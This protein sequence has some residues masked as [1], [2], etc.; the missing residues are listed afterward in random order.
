MQPI[1]CLP[2]YIAQCQHRIDDCPQQRIEERQY[3][4]FLKIAAKSNL[5][6]HQPNLLFLV[7]PMVIYVLYKRELFQYFVDRPCFFH[8]EEQLSADPAFTKMATTRDFV[9]IWHLKVVSSLARN[10][11]VSISDTSLF[12]LKKKKIGNNH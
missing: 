7:E 11:N 6:P 1:F 5:C 12:L 8:T 9:W 4:M 10:P 3:L 2:T